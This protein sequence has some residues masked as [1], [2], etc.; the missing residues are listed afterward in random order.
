MTI[1]IANA[2]QEIREIVEKC[3]KCGLCKSHCPVFKVLRE[4]Q[5]SPR[6]KTILLDNNHFEK[7]IYNCTLCKA[8]EE[9]CPHN[10]QLCTAFTKARQVLISQK[11]E[12]QENKEMIKNL[13]KTGNIFGIR[14]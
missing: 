7:L 3:I 13:E 10:L 11:K 8:C 4:E 1:E 5:S 12:I 6:G 14:E 9:K 2:K